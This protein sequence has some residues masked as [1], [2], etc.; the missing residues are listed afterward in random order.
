[1]KRGT[2][3]HVADLAAEK[4]VTVDELQ[5]F[6]H[7]LGEACAP[8]EVPFLFNANRYSA[9]FG[10]LITKNPRYG[11]SVFEPQ[12]GIDNIPRTVGKL[13][14]MRDDVV[15]AFVSTSGATPEVVTALKTAYDDT[16]DALVKSRSRGV[17]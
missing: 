6:G 14:A 8:I 15:H 3:T 4:P 1:M 13:R 11:R 7:M 16:V 5:R 12:S 9:V 10:E 2:G 17:V